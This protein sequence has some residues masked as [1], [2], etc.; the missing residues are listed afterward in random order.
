MRLGR[1][2]MEV[3]TIDGHETPVLTRTEL[4]SSSA[5]SCGGVSNPQGMVMVK[6]PQWLSSLYDDDTMGSNSRS[7]RSI[8][9]D[10]FHSE[11]GLIHPNRTDEE[12]GGEE[13][14]R[15]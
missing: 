12:R 5:H 4:G 7:F 15:N 3:S 13:E 10:L 8:D 1:M 14:K 2:G 9:L 6:I 11:G